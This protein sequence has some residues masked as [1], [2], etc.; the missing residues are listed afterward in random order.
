MSLND[1]G[2]HMGT[3]FRNGILGVHMARAGFW[4]G[5]GMHEIPHWHRISLGLAFIHIR[6]SDLHLS[7]VSTRRFPFLIQL[8]IKSQFTSAFSFHPF[9]NTDR[10]IS[11]QR[12]LPIFRP[13]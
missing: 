13:D 7:F 6:G 10:R 3:M 2:H 11:L 1:C 9:V 12:S 8:V 5:L 4:F